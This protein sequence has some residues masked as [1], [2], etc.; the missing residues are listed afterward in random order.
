MKV[1]SKEVRKLVFTELDR[2]DPVTVIIDDIASGQGSITIC[3]FGKAWTSYWGA[4]G[5]G[6]VTDFFLDS[7]E[8]YLAKNLSSVDASVIDYDSI[9]EKI[10]QEVDVTTLMLH[11]TEVIE[12]YGD[13]WP[14]CLPTKKNHEYQYL[15]RIIKA[16]QQG[17]ATVHEGRTQPG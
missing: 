10:S 1:K 7:D 9:S 5:N 17:L 3:C 6:D 11:V 13:D 14:D 8:H 4:M 2:L 16:V 12:A 15:C